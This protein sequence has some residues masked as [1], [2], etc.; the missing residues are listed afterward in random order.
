MLYPETLLNSLVSFRRLL[1]ESLGF[2]PYKVM[3]SA[4]KD[5]TESSCPVWAPSVS[6]PC[7]GPGG[8]RAPSSLSDNCGESGCVCLAP[9]LRG[10]LSTSHP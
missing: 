6:S 5:I 4:D 1:V 9:D 8:G 2:P 3:A 10:S 7:R